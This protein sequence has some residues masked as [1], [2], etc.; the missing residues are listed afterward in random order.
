MEV[1]AGG[2]HEVPLDLLALALAHQAVVDVHAG[3]PVADRPLDERGGHGRVDTAGQAADRVPAVT[4]LALDRLHLLLDDV[5]H[6]PGRAAARDLQQEVL[7]HLLPVLGVHDLG[8]PLDA[9]QAAVDRFEGGDRRHRRGGEYVEAGRRSGHGVAVG[10][11]HGVLGRDLGEQRPGDAHDHRCPAVL[12]RTRV[13]HGPPERLRHQLEPVAHAEDR[14]PRREDRGVDARGALGVDRRRPPGEDDRLRLPRQ[15]LGHRHGVGHDLGVDPRLADPA[16]DQLGV[17]RPEVDH[18]DQI[19]L[20]VLH[21]GGSVVASG[22]RPAHG[23]GVSTT[24]AA[25]AA[26]PPVVAGG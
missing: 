5:D 22:H 4:D 13:G 1:D 7:E 3:E 21:H 18:Q 8:V 2:R 16:G 20:G 12:A 11:P 25:L 10:H 6:R 24:L 26:E 14:H 19:V 23:S 17:L 9:S 15:H